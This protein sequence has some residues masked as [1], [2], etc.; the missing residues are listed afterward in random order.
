M[1][2][3]ELLKRNDL[4]FLKGCLIMNEKEFLLKQLI[5]LPLDIKIAKTKLRIKEFYEYFDGQVYV[6]FSG[7]KD[8]T[9]LAHIARQIYPEIPLVFSD[10]GLEYPEIRDFVKTIENVTWLKPA[11]L[12]KDVIKKYGYPVISKEVASN[13]YY[14]KRGS[15]W[16]INNLNGL[17][18]NGYK[19]DF[20]QRYIK[21]KY[22]INAPFNISS[23]C[24]EKLKKEPFKRYERESGRKPII[25]TMTGESILR[26]QSWLKNGCNSF[27]PK[28]EKSSPLSF[29]KESDIWEYINKFNIGYSSIYDMGYERTGCMFCA[30]GCHLE[31]KNKFDLMKETHPE[32]YNYCMKSI[33][34]GG[35]GMYEVL[36][37]LN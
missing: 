31:E 24:C 37:Y 3:E 27:N 19:S 35:L 26:K 32:I 9:V 25:G 16:A 10:T 2:G 8:S 15:S 36:K 34:S 6:S 17:D 7:G 18:K 29:W 28:K 13:I 23:Y 5:A 30:F 14:A 12:F 4:F 20:K 21:Y 33:E 22:L 11:M 1:V